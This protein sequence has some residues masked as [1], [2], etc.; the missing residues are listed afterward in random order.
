MDTV[1]RAWLYRIGAVFILALIAVD[2]AT[3]GDAEKWVAWV[4][5]AIGL[6][7]AGLAAKNTPTKG[8][9]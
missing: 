8:D 3:G 7:T 9:R 4:A 5:G 6:G 1:T 2:V